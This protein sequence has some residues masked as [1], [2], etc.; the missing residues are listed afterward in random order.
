MN[1]NV[2][3]N[4]LYSFSWGYRK[5]FDQYAQ[6][7]HERFPALDI[8]GDNYPPP[9]GRAAVAQFLSIFKLFVI[10]MIVSG[11]N[12]FPHLNMETPSLFN[13]ATENKV[14]NK[15]YIH[16]KIYNKSV[17]SLE[18][19][20]IYML[21]FWWSIFG[22][23]FPQ[24]LSHCKKYN[25][26][27]YILF[28]VLLESFWFLKMTK[29]KIMVDIGNFISFEGQLCTV[30]IKIYLILLCRFMHVSWCFSSVMPLKGKWF[31]LVP[32]RSLLMVM[33]PNNCT[34]LYYTGIR[35]YIMIYINDEY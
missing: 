28:C 13:W 15:Y 35:N 4:F 19:I 31:Q 17:K 8:Q 23:F 14:L 10:V 12:P 11:Q 21:I 29:I 6:L 1:I 5:V 26:L 18:F 16:I 30:P 25:I 9:S 33:T 2:L 7:L 32:L 34:F 27:N 24:S 20:Y 3:K 22:F